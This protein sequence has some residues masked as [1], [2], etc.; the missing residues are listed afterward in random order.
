MTRAVAL[1]AACLALLVLAGC[2]DDVPFPAL[3]ADAG[4]SPPDAEV[5]LPDAG[6]ARPCGAHCCAAGQVCDGDTEKC[7][8]CLPD[9]VQKQCGP[10]GCGGSCG[11]CAAGTRCDSATQRCA[12]C[13]PQCAGR[14]CGDDGCNGQCG[15]C[16]AQE[17]C[18]AAGQCEACVPD[19]AR[20]RCGDDGCGG[21]CGTCTDGK[22]CDA[23]TSQCVTTTAPDGGCVPDCDG[24]RCG[25]DGCG[26]SC[27]QCSSGACSNGTC[28]CVAGGGSCA[29]S[30][31]CCSGT[32]TAAGTCCLAAGATCTS[33]ASC[34]AGA[35]QSGKCCAPIGASCG[36]GA[37]CCSGS[38]VGGACAC[39]PNCLGKVCGEDGCGG[40]CGTCPA[41]STCDNGIVCEGGAASGALLFT[42][43]YQTLPDTG[44]TSVQFRCAG[45]VAD[46]GKRCNRNTSTYDLVDLSI[47]GYTYDLYTAC[48]N[49]VG[50]TGLSCLDATGS[51]KHTDALAGLRLLCDAMGHDASLTEGYNDVLAT[52]RW[53]AVVQADPFVWGDYGSPVNSS[54]Y[55]RCD[56]GSA[57]V[58]QCNGRACGIDGCG[59]RCGTCAAGEACDS[60]YRCAT[61]LVFT[62]S[63]QVLP[64]TDAT[65]VEFRCAGT[66]S[67]GGTRCDRAADGRLVELRFD[68]KTVYDLYPGCDQTDWYCLD[69]WVPSG[70]LPKWN[71]PLAGLELLCDA[72]GYPAGKTTGSDDLLDTGRATAIVQVN[73]FMYGWDPDRRRSSSFIQCAP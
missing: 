65:T 29:S 32:C 67:A 57:C 73:N 48:G 37:Q 2:P 21:S 72:M 31:D 69:T 62:N 4:V 26:G 24:K 9:C 56:G 34:C 36:S 38:C 52:G 30:S 51:F 15:A 58:P 16:G 53:V 44:S 41:G 10:D 3:G 33:G 63:F 50:S 8:A 46:G 19:C 28:A 12:A 39:R 22:A 55:I 11:E 14:E 27:G 20:R 42:T 43:S 47:D 61:P 45:T 60:W 6:C 1:P 54:T 68:G 25:D 40:S 70:T 66:V 23:E 18:S 5:A 35:C 64:N 49:P 59:G 71:D 7:V 17:R 13:S